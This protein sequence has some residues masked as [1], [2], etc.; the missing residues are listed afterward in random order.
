MTPTDFELADTSPCLLGPDIL[1]AH[2]CGRSFTRAEWA[3]LPFA[4]V[5]MCVASLEPD[6][7]FTRHVFRHCPCG[8]TIGVDASLDD[9]E[10]WR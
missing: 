2:A 3:A 4:Y 8:S 10:E 5:D 1:R 6:A 7:P 9:G